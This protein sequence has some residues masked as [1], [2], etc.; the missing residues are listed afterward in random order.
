[1]FDRVFHI[2]RTCMAQSVRWLYTYFYLP[3]TYKSLSTL[4]KLQYI[5]CCFVFC[6]GY[7][8]PKSNNSI[9]STNKFIAN[10]RSGNSCG[11]ACGSFVASLLYLERLV[12]SFLEMNSRHG[13]TSIQSMNMK[14]ALEIASL[15]IIRAL[16]ASLSS[17][18]PFQL[19]LHPYFLYSTIPL[20]NPLFTPNLV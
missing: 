12:C 7:A 5:L 6:N 3:L 19:R 10:W 18:F 16:V 17:I 1:M 9:L 2:T 4:R 15:Q 8:F 14:D 20:W 13:F 11:N